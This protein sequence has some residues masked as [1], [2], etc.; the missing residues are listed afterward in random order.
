MTTQH[1]VC[2]CAAVSL[3]IGCDD[4]SDPVVSDADDTVD[5]TN[6]DTVEDTLVPDTGDSDD[7]DLEN[8]SGDS[9][10]T[11]LEGDSGDSDDTDLE[12]TSV[13][14]S[15]VED[16]SD[17]AT[18]T[19]CPETVATVAGVTVFKNG[20]FH[21]IKALGGQG[22]GPRDITVYL[23]A[24]YDTS[25]AAAERYPVLYA[26]DGQNLFYAQDAAFGVE[27]G[28]DE[29]LDAAL[30][31][32]AISGPVIVV[33]LNNTSD[34]ISDYTPT[35]D[36]DFGG[37]NGAAYGAYLVDVVKP[38]IDQLYRTR[39]GRADTAIMGSSLGGLISFYLGL[40]YP[41]VFGRVAAV[42]P[43]LWWD[44]QSLLDVFDGYSGMLPDRLWIDM[45]TLEGETTGDLSASVANV[46]HARDRAIARGARTGLGL[47]Y[48]EAP[49]ATH[50]EASWRARL[51]AILAYLFGPERSVVDQPE[52]LAIGLFSNPLA[53]G[54][55]TNMWVNA[56]YSDGR[57]LTIPNPE[58]GLNWMNGAAQLD[59]SGHIQAVSPGETVVSAD[60]QAVVA[61][62]TLVVAQDGDSTLVTFEVDVPMS[63]PAGDTVYLTG[64]LP[65]LS[66]WDPAGVAMT[67]GSDG[68]WSVTLAIAQ[69]SGF[70]YKYTRGSWLQVEVD[71]SGDDL[72][73]RGAS[74]GG[75]AMTLHDTV[76]GWHDGGP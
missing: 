47:G 12:D 29:V 26:H 56:S 35:S 51:P 8:D 70:A 52:T 54:E 32:Q 24:S 71:A 76:Q 31:E 21:T 34:R 41:D 44:S 25:G 69:G 72:G 33:G 55:T 75:A 18:P 73:N 53:V 22:V 14:D 9:D 64:D 15:A 37:G 57:R 17:T 4:T 74:A 13:A 16:V 28:L 65:V 40:Q 19:T 48:L 59:E 11:D 38:A 42:S 39:C 10:D 7:T 45:G 58:A 1:L 27:W 46:R 61:T 63:T 6:T 67:A 43:S 20:R 23:P 3:L 5:A 36:L 66:V 68:R 49:G 30:S 2:L 50:D 60:Y 62:A